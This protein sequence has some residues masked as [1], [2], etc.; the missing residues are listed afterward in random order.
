MASAPRLRTKSVSKP[1]NASTSTDAMSWIHVASMETRLFVGKSVLSTPTR[2]GHKSSHCVG[3]ATVRPPGAGDRV[4]Q[5]GGHE[6]QAGARPAG[7]RD[8]LAMGG[9][10]AAAVWPRRGCARPQG[11]SDYGHAACRGSCSAP[12]DREGADRPC[13]AQWR[14]IL[15]AVDRCQASTH[16]CAG[17]SS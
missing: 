9:R 3:A 15:P 13:W 1:S 2:T 17:S 7:W 11:C 8:N 4:R 12:A 14:R 6:V 10:G 16:Q 5:A